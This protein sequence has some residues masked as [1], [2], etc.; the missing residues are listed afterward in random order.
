M[1]FG[2]TDLSVSRLGIGCAA[3]GG[4]DYGRV[5]DRESIAAI[6]RA[7]DLGVNFFDT[8]DVYGFGHAEEVLGTALGTRRDKVV[9]ATKGGIRWDE[10]GRTI[11]DLSPQWIVRA[12]EN[13]LRRLRLDCIP[14]YQIHWPDPGTPIAET[15]QALKK[16][17]SEGKIKFIG[18]CNFSRDLFQ[19][20]QT[21]CRLESL[22]VPY[23][24]AERGFRETIRTYYEK[25]RVAVLAYSPL[26]QGLLSGKYSQKSKFEGTDLRRHSVLF[27]GMK[28]EENLALLE[29][30][31]T[32]GRRYGRSPSQVAI[33]WVLEESAVA[34]A[35]TGV[36]R[37]EQVEENSGAAGWKL[38]EEDVHFL[39]EGTAASES[40]FG[41]QQ[42]N[43]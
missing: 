14:V 25:L 17:Q 30:I 43:S 39:E 6:Q 20:A 8:A 21:I 4:Y 24:L 1:Q 40:M 41:L 28:L 16:S 12:L 42:N 10:G 2:Q 31:R 29:R 23:S 36:K 22:Q 3:I 33:R 7:I 9:V 35:M 26:A 37:P 13:S 19:Q 18:C 5:D 15:L 27:Q 38:A 11:R 32:V 34:C